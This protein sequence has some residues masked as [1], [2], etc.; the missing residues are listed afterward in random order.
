MNGS[1]VNARVAVIGYR[2]LASSLL[3]GEPVRIA[4]RFL[5]GTYDSPMMD[6]KVMSNDIRFIGANSR[7]I[8]LHES[9]QERYVRRTDVHNC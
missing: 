5:M 4:T 1:G 6:V 3:I 7:R 2:F 8:R 9:Q